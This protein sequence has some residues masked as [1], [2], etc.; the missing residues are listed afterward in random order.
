MC[1]KKVTKEQTGVGTTG[2]SWDGIEELN[3]PLPRWW[4]WIFYI[5]IVFAIGYSV[6][7]PAIPLLNSATRGVLNDN[8]RTNLQTDLDKWDAQNGD[9]KAKLVAADVNAIP[10]DAAL[11]GFAENAGKAVFNTN[12]IQ[13]HM[14]EG[15]G[16]KAKGYPTLSDND[17]LYG[18]TMDAIVTTISHGV[19]NTTDPEARNVGILMPA[20]STDDAPAKLTTEQIDQVVNYVLKLS[21]QDHDE[22]AATAGLQLFTDNCVACH[23]E[24]AKGNRDMGSPNLTDA[25]WLYGGDK[26][27]LIKTVTYGQGGVMPSWAGRLSE[28]D[29]RSAAAYVHALGGGE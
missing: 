18:G 14:R 27:Q 28:A 29:I 8:M 26:A 11:K 2:H 15:Q 21:G 4:V 23:G 10:T 22:A 6:A 17:W 3:N 25:I 16:N 24:D 12:C 19:R 9:I 5:C 13:C 7:Y 1:A 20:W